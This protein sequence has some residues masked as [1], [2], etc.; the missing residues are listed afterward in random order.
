MGIFTVEKVD[1]TTNAR[2][3]YFETAHGRV[4]TPVFMPVGTQAT[5]KSLTPKDLAEIGARIILNNTYHLYLRPGAE[6]I[7][8]YGGVHAFQSW[9]GPILTDS[10]GFQVFS[11]GFGQAKRQQVV[12]KKVKV[13][14]EGIEEPEVSAKI[15]EDGV[16]FQSHIDGS[17]HRFTPEVSIETQHKLGADLIIAFDEC[18][19]YPCSKEY[20]RASMERTN[21]WA[22]RSLDRHK[23]LSNMKD[24]PNRQQRLFGVIQGGVYE[25][26][27]R[28]SATFIGQN[29]FDGICVGGVSA[30]MPKEQIY[31]ICDWISP[32][33]PEDKPRHLLGI[34]DID[35]IFNGIERGVDMFD[36]VAP[37][38]LARN[39]ALFISPKS[40]G[41]VKN[42]FRRNIL[43]AQ[44]S[45][46]QGPVDGDCACYTCQNF[47]LAYL[48]HLFIANELL[49]YRLATYHNVYF[50]VQLVRHIRQAILNDQFPALKKHWLT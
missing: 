40:G 41:A 26:L 14:P 15:D 34:G 45:G 48:R 50:I 16:T 19:P 30:G 1:K 43:N 17:L 33:L 44:C 4:E 29:D 10:G 36:C 35:D 24:Q 11:L 46:E 22:K 3:G 27:Q 25:A 47:S 32:L 8:N 39:G 2:A 37:T 9:D 7:N 23:Q 18:M 28:Q 12:S 21:R 13:V 42:R 5:V 6:F 49:A 38:R 31:T 20:A